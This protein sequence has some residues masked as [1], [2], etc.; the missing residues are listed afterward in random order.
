LTGAA[1]AARAPGLRQRL[2]GNLA[3]TVVVTRPVAMS[4]TWP[5]TLTFG[6]SEGEASRRSTSARTV[7]CGSA[8][9]EA[10]SG[11]GLAGRL[12]G[13]MPVA[14]VGEKPGSALRVVHDRDLE[15]PAAL[16]LLAEQLLGQEGEV[17]D[18][19]DDGLGNASARVA[20]DGRVGELEPEDDRRVDPVVEAGDD[21]HL[22]G[23]RAEGRGGIGAGELLVALEQR[24][25]PGH[26]DSSL[27]RHLV[28]AVH[29]NGD[30]GRC[31]LVML[32][33]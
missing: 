1:A 8:T 5:E 7:T 31:P 19:V 9:A 14:G 32:W 30:C 2:P 11:L 18:V 27:L 20:D 22:P 33:P 13:L 25:H 29:V 28:D 21:D 10:A 24:G 23:G 4:Y 17:V 16:E 26:G 6:E 15:E 12:G 3:S